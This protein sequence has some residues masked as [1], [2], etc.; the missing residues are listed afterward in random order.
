MA[1]EVSSV[2]GSEVRSGECLLV[3]RRVGNECR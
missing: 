3:K 2:V 1:W